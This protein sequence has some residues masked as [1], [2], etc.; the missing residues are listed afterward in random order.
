MRDSPGIIID[1]EQFEQLVI[2]YQTALFGFLGGMGFHQ[3]LA[4]DL[5]QD[6]FLRAWRS[7][8]TFD[9]RKGHVSTWLF[10]IARNLA[11]DEIRRNENQKTDFID[12]DEI[13]VSDDSQS[14]FEDQ[15]QREIRRKVQAGLSQL[16]VDDRCALSLGYLRQLTAPE[17][18]LVL[19]CSAGAFRTRLTRA[20]QRL[21]STLEN[22]D[23]TQ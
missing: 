3:S 22:L 5:A 9:G 20:R 7:R 2:R 23:A 10:R 17:A 16:S 8:H 1:E 13:T 6:T 12:M 19:G 15:Y 4:E 14:S 18:A 11:Y 21:A